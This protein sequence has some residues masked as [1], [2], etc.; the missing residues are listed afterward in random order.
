MQY[1]NT[2]F[3]V[4]RCV[5]L[6]CFCLKQKMGKVGVF[7]YRIA[8]TVSKVVNTRKQETGESTFIV[9]YF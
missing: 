9:H 3:L 5:K 2:V 4:M 1:G 6:L 7:L 8:N